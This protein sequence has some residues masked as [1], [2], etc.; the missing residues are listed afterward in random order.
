MEE[1]LDR[2]TS[3]Y[4]QAV[5][6]LQ[7]KC[8]GLSE[9]HRADTEA[10]QRLEKQTGSL[11]TIL[12]SEEDARL[13]LMKR[14]ANMPGVDVKTQEVYHSPLESMEMYGHMRSPHHSL[15]VSLLHK[16]PSETE[17]FDLPVNI[18]RLEGDISEL[19]KQ[20]RQALKRSYS[21]K[22]DL[23]QLRGDLSK[24]TKELE[25]KNMTLYRLKRLQQAGDHQG[26]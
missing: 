3:E 1:E 25:A 2:V 24:Y 15:S 26:Y 7:D 11:K 9:T 17:S 22:G 18:A 12:A 16:Q 5:S 8:Y 20:Y 6:K 19:K 21:N 13:M 14:M 4:A 23:A 10:I